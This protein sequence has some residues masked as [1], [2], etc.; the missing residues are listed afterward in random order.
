MKLRTKNILREM[1]KHFGLKVKFVSYFG[2]AVHGKLL[3]REKRILINAHKPRYEHIFTLFHEI[4]H[5]FIHFKNPRR[6]HYPGF[7]EIQ[8]NI[9]WLDDLASKVR[10]YL[11]RLFNKETGQ[12]WEADLWAMILFLLVSK[13]TG[14]TDD[15]RTFLNHHPEKFWIFMLAS[16]TLIYCGIKNRIT[17][18][19]Q[20]LL[21]PFRPG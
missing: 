10:R 11:R 13:F 2:D 17:R 9:Q 4:G 21:K 5:F 1:A 14:N 19:F 12:E 7:L 15:L 3:P 20:I 16:T 6:K 8:W 18:P